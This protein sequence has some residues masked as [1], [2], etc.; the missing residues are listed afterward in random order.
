[1]RR[2][3]IIVFLIVT[4]MATTSFVSAINLQNSKETT[5]V[6]E[7]DPSDIKYS[8]LGIGG[9]HDEASLTKNGE[10][11]SNLERI[12]G[13]GGGW[14]KP[15]E[16]SGVR[17][18]AENNRVMASYTFDINEGPVKYVEYGVRYRDVGWLSDSPDAKIYKWNDNW[19]SKS[20]I[21]DHE[22]SYTWAYHTFSTN[23]LEY[24]NDQGEVRVAAQAFDDGSW[25]H[26]DNIGINKMKVSYQAADEEI[27][28][29]N[30]IRYDSDSDGSA[31]SI[32][33]QV[34]AD[35]GDNADGTT[36]DVTA[37][38][39][40]LD[41][42]GN[43][44]GSESVTWTIVD[45]QMD[46]GIVHLSSIGGINGDYTLN[47]ELYDYYG[48]LED[49]Y[50]EIVFLEPD[51]QRNILFQAD[52][53]IGG[54]INFS[55]TAYYDNMSALT[56]DGA[57]IVNATPVDYF[58][59][60]HWEFD[61]GV[62]I[63]S[64][65]IYSQETEVTI[66][67]N[68]TLRAIFS[69]TLNT[70]YF[71]VV[72]DFAGVILISDTPFENGTAVLAEEGM[73]IIEAVPAVNDYYFYYWE[74]Y[75]DISVEDEYNYNTTLT[76]VGDGALVAYFNEN[77]PP[78]KPSI[79]DG[80]IAGATQ[81]EYTYSSSTT[82][83]DGDDLYYWFDWGDGTNSGWL[84][85]YSNG[86]IV[87][88]S[89]KW[90]GSRVYQVRVKA[91]DSYN[92]E[93]EWSDALPVGIY[94]PPNPPVITG[95]TTGKA[96]TELIFTIYAIDPDD[97]DVFFYIEWGDGTFE[98][99]IGPYG[100]GDPTT[101]THTFQKKGTYTVRAQSKDINDVVSQSWGNLVV[102]MPKPKVFNSPFFD[103]LN[104]RFQFFS[105]I[106]RILDILDQWTA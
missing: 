74:T 63:D 84:G 72:P 94:S 15:F 96:G 35:V 82:D 88:A 71:F 77:A 9:W 68:G 47:I 7:E 83:P 45:H 29:T 85:P 14:E 56:S 97:E 38:C 78:L 65:D 105:F 36:V 25:L 61:G 102:E 37:Q 58:I 48:N 34:D 8:T 76:V 64:E 44:S 50:S 54:Y 40:L 101:V 31:D 89:H 98:N 16:G 57:Y 3:I 104:S 5:V 66:N 75:G 2:K 23:N 53:D 21:G 95:P 51:P 6:D 20:N 18:W 67:D 33:V 55:G 93:S 81:Q 60:S 79:P 43:V 4:L 32:E 49:E 52:P 46:Q 91:K 73:Y 30:I 69:F 19:D 42:E 22:G 86:Y 24:V 99:W 70:I 103:F 26:Q 41:P 87:S 62:S 12:G 17:I 100:S 59:F 106:E 90:A 92:A 80:P 1:M 28:V 39:T 27:Y 10:D 11:T 13:S